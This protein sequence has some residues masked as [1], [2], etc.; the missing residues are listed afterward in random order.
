[1]GLEKDYA[2]FFKIIGSGGETRLDSHVIPQKIRR[3]GLGFEDSKNEIIGSGK[4]TT[5][6]FLKFSGLEERLSSIL[7]LF[8]REKVI[9]PII[10]SG[11]KT[12]RYTDA[13][14]QGFSFEE[15]RQNI[16]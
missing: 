3:S 5:F 7:T 2:L 12:A 1:M 4:K 13:S 14:V 16:P 10:G 9:G 11:I 15:I 6:L 8:H